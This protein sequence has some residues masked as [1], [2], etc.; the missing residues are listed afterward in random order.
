MTHDE[1][2]AVLTDPAS[3]PE[4]RYEAHATLTAAAAAGDAQAEATLHWLRYN[5]SGRS[6][7]D[8]D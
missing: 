5:R 1:A 3:P 7:C 2:V 4:T 8:V 6:A